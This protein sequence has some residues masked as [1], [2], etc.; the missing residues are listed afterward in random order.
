MSEISSIVDYID[1]QFTNSTGIF[2]GKPFQKGLYNGLC[3]Q[4][5]RKEGDKVRKQIIKFDDA[6]GVD[7]A[8][9]YVDD[10]YPF[11]TYHRVKGMK[12]DDEKVEDFFGDDG[13]QKIVTFE[14]ALVGI[15]DKLNVQIDRDEVVTGLA[16]NLPTAIKPISISGSQFSQ[17]EI[18]S[19]NVVIDTQ[20]VFSQEYGEDSIIPQNIY[21]FEY[22]YEVKL[23]YNKKCFT[24][25]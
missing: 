3:K 16:V 13:E 18:K 22:V 4:I 11:Q 7:A 14:V 20:D 24:L 1:T 15:V 21:I 19:D 17:C 8:G 2:K 23:N 5:D 12:I 10:L 25:C 6:K 9:V